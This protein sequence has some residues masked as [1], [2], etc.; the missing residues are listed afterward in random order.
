MFGQT[1]K[2]WCPRCDYWEFHYVQRNVAECC[3]CL[4]PHEIRDEEMEL[5]YES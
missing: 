3:Y 4:E 1:V 2:L 5:I